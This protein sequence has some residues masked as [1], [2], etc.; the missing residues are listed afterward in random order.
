MSSIVHNTANKQPTD[1]TATLSQ[2]HGFS[3]RLEKVPTSKV[4]IN[5]AKPIMEIASALWPLSRAAAYICRYRIDAAI[6][7]TALTR[8]ART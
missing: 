2:D 3:L 1:A 6:E 8:K 5:K 4:V 7:M